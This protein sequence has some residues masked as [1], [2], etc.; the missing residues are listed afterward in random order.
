M[1]TRFRVIDD[2]IDIE[3]HLVTIVQY[4]FRLYAKKPK[5]TGS[6]SSAITAKNRLD[7]LWDAN[8]ISPEL[9]KSIDYIFQVRNKF[10]HLKECNNWTALRQY[11]N[12]KV[13]LDHIK[14]ESNLS[15][16]KSESD[17]EYLT[18]CWVEFVNGVNL[19]LDKLRFEL[20]GGIHVE[21]LR[22][23]SEVLLTKHLSDIFHQHHLDFINKHPQQRNN[24][25]L[26]EYLNKLGDKVSKHL[27]TLIDDHN[28]LSLEE[29]LR[30][31]EKRTDS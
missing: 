4:A 23:Y 30:I 10:A 19:Q 18:K 17:E 14:K 13:A 25:L 9:H 22:F 21:V 11:D 6:N 7:L 1:E 16:Q 26:I 15:P 3:S 5:A 31:F 29:Q 27:F 20:I 24:P 12:G 2:A 8:F 28:K